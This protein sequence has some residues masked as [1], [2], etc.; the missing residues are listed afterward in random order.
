MNYLDI[1][2][3][4]IKLWV[5]GLILHTNYI[6]FLNYNPNNPIDNKDMQLDLIF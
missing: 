1:Y 2:N 4:Q 3:F 5:P 6:P